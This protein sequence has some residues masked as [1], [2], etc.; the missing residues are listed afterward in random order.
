IVGKRERWSESGPTGAERKRDGKR[1]G[2]GYRVGGELFADALDGTAALGQRD[3][4]RSKARV[5]CFGLL[6]RVLRIHGYHLPPSALPL[7]H[8]ARH[9]GLHVRWA[10]V[11]TIA[12]P[13]RALVC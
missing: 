8:L 5:L 1:A 9:T 4:C 2:S 3:R 7:P 13:R 10:V 11:T 6:R 12:H